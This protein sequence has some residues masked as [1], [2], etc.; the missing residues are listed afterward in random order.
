LYRK[1]IEALLG[2]FKDSGKPNMQNDYTLSQRSN[3]Q[4]VAKDF[5]QNASLSRD[6]GFFAN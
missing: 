5:A 6:E 4:Y 1:T 2:I 3:P